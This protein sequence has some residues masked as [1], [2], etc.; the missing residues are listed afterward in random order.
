MVLVWGM[1]AL[2]GSLTEDTVQEIVSGRGDY[3]DETRNAV[4]NFEGTP[5]TYLGL[6]SDQRSGFMGKVFEII[7]GAEID[8]DDVLEGYS[9]IVL[10]MAKSDE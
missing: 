4:R 5:P 6:S 3:D 9:E 10:F 1:T 8:E 2:A 7:E